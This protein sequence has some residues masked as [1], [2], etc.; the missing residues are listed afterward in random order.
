MASSDPA[1]HERVV[2]EVAR[3]AGTV[4]MRTTPPAMGQLIHRVVRAA[5]GVDDPYRDLKSTFNRQALS[6]YPRLSLAVETADDPFEAALRFS[7][8]GNIIDCGAGNNPSAETLE[9]AVDA[10]WGPSLDPDRVGRLRSALDGAADVLYLGD[11]AGEIVFDRLLVE[12][13]GPSRV[14]FAV[15]GAPVLNDATLED[16]R[17]TGL[18]N[19]VG[20]I[21][22]GSDAPGTLLDDC[23]AEFVSRFRGASV[24][25]A[26]G[27]G[28]FESLDPEPGRV[29]FVLQAK[30]PV[31]ARDLGCSVGDFVVTD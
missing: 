8:A 16:A 28:N 10:A 2:R 17:D 11:N 23:S 6:V 21:D 30:C 26:K 25:I 15:R 3:A 12:R 20:V 19:I 24:V 9:R 31:I 1:V 4:E 29:F 27:Q 5:S 18:S 7:I 22:N 13:I 14:T